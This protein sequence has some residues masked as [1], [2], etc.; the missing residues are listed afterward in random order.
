[1]VGRLKTSFRYMYASYLGLSI[2]RAYSSNIVYMQ[3][4]VSV[5]RFAGITGVSAGIRLC[6]RA[7]VADWRISRCRGF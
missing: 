2:F 6:H 7:N 3:T 4:I 5:D 1:M